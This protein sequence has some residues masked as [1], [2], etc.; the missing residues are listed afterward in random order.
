MASCRAYTLDRSSL[1]AMGTL[2]QTV[3]PCGAARAT[4]ENEG[5]DVGG[6]DSQ[7]SSALSGM[8]THQQMKIQWRA[9]Q[10]NK[11]KAYVRDVLFPTTK[12]FFDDDSFAINGP[13]GR[14]IVRRGMG[15]RTSDPEVLDMW[16]VE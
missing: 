2:M 9:N 7:D 6:A 1:G 3:T 5:P 4:N 8:L 16:V 11:G 13:L 15:L 12:L 10:I 14:R